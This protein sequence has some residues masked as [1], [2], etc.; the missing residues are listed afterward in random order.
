MI[1]R[2]IYMMY[3]DDNDWVDQKKSKTNQHGFP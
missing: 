1:Y 3:S 2:I